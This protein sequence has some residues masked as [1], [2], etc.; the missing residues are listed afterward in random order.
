ME[1]HYAYHCETLDGN[2]EV[3]KGTTISDTRKRLNR[4]VRALAKLSEAAMVACFAE[5]DGTGTSGSIVQD[6]WRNKCEHR[7]T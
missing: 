7:T 1:W 2:Q 5:A 6:S 4:T 3:I